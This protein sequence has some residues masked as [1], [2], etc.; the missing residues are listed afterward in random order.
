MRRVC[1]ALTLSVLLSACG[2]GGSSS[3]PATAP[4]ATSQQLSEAQ[5]A[6][7]TAT[8]NATNNLASLAW[9]DT[10]PA[11]SSYS[12]EQLAPDGTWSSLDAVP[13]TTGMGAVLTWTRTINSATTLRVV[14]AETGYSVPLETASGNASVMVSPPSSVPTIALSQ[15]QPVSGDVTLSISG[16]G[17]FSA[18]Q[19]FVDL[20]SIGSSTTAPDY[21]IALNAGTLTQGS[22]LILAQLQTSPDSQLLIRLTIQTQNPEVSINARTVGTS[23]LVDLDVNATAASGIASVSATLDANVLGTLTAPNCF[24]DPS[25]SYQFAIDA[26][27]AGSGTHTVSVRATDNDGVSASQT[28]Q[29]M[30][31]DPPRLVVTTPIDGALVN[32]TLA[33]AGTFDTDRPGVTVSVKATLGSVTILNTSSSPFS[34]S[35]S[36]AGVNPGTYTLTV[37]AIDSTGLATTMTDSVTVTSSP[38]LV[39]TPVLTLGSAGSILA[40]SNLGFV[41]QDSS[42]AT[43]VHTPAGDQ[44]LALPG[45][46]GIAGWQITD[47]GHVFAEASGSDRPGTSVYMWAP[48]ATTATNLSAAASS[49]SRIDQLLSVH[50][51][52]VLWASFETTTW[53]QYTLYNVTTAEN[54]TVL[55]PAGT[56]VLGNINCDFA[57]VSGKLRL[58]F[59]ADDASGMNI[60]SWNQATNASTQLTSDGHSIYP[61]TDGTSV[62]WESSPLSPPLVL[63]TEAILSGS[64]AVLSTN[65]SNFQLNSGVLAWLEQTISASTVTAQAI[66]VSNGGTVSTL[67]NVLSS[68]LF[69]SNG[70]FVA[71]EQGGSLYD[72]SAAGGPV[73]LF[74]AAP[75]QVH[76][77]SSTLYFTNGASQTVYSVPMH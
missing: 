9:L 39:Y 1:V 57:T 35:F 23:G 53:S 45:A 54:L 64:P 21:S 72:W 6:K 26:I 67:T 19:W 61:Q 32:G 2:G 66:K 51:P 42:G 68:V 58:F 43:H 69:G 47:D 55:S 75:S 27:A 30:F 44:T 3:I 8:L 59:W 18:V 17:T 60:Y 46:A 36:L 37:V 12:I 49:Q 16:G 77:A 38:S 7:L 73:L 65:M 13:G 31:A 74:D 4:T 56:T 22:H 25:C 41:Y 14:V 50:F 5:S 33:I 48:G 70:G 76:L 11:G 10:F 52:W 40:V 28:F 15:T 29:V 63:T 20:N 24:I 62:A 71:Y 34:S